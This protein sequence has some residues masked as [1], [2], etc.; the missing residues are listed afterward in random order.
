MRREVGSALPEAEMRG[1]EL[2]LELGE[3]TVYGDPLLA[4]AEHGARG[5]GQRRV[6]LARA[7]SASSRVSSAP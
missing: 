3:G 2:V 1:D 7:V 4:G 5:E 6:L